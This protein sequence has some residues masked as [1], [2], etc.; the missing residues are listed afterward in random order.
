MSDLVITSRPHSF[1]IL[2][3]V[4]PYVIFKQEHVSESLRFFP[5]LSRE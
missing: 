1:D 3:E 4:E 2:Q 5:G